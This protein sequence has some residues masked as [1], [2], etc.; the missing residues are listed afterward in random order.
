MAI[1]VHNIVFLTW[2]FFCSSCVCVF[3]ISGLSKWVRQLVYHHDTFS[4]A[5]Q[6]LALFCEEQLKVNDTQ[7][8]SFPVSSLKSSTSV[9][10]EREELPESSNICSLSA[11]MKSP[12]KNGSLTTFHGPTS[13]KL[14]T[15]EDKKEGEERSVWCC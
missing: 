5:M 15:E 14:K 11:C 1:T 3:T 7:A 9:L 2:S 4:K 13:A 8:S 12:E 6:S 10:I